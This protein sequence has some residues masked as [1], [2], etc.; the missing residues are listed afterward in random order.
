MRSG[1]ILFGILVALVLVGLVAGVGVFTYNAGVAQGLVT[2]GKLVPPSSDGTIPPVPYYAPLGLYRP[3]FGFGLFGCLGPILFFF[4]ILFLLRLLFWGPR[5]RR[6]WGGRP[7]RT[8]DFWDPAQGNIPQGVRELHR[9]LHEQEAGTQPPP[10]AE[11][12]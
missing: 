11:P 12:R 10:T 5:W 6:G 8:G 4:F 9:K 7:W 3:W 2:S 1:R